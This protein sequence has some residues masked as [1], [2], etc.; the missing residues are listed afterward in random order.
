M[1][2]L[3]GSEISLER[4]GSQIQQLYGRGSLPI[5]FQGWRFSP[6][7]RVPTAVDLVDVNISHTPERSPTAT[8]AKRAYTHHHYQRFV[9]SVRKCQSTRCVTRSNF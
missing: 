3:S 5:K 8:L 2:P 4:Q 7:K 9:E 6:C 1:D